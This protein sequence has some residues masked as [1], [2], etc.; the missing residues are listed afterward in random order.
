MKTQRFVDKGLD[1]LVPEGEETPYDEYDVPGPVPEENDDNAP[2]TKKRA[3]GGRIV[4]ANIAS[5]PS[6]AQKQNGNYAKDHISVDGF[7]ITIEN[8]KGSTR[9]GVGADGK[10]WECTMPYNY[11][12]FK[13]SEG[14]DGDHVD[15]CLGPHR[16]SPYVFVVDQVDAKTKKF[17]EH[18]VGLHWGT[19]QQ[20][21]NAYKRGFSDGKGK[22]RIGAVTAVSLP[23]F[24]VWLKH[25]DTTKPFSA[26]LL[27][28]G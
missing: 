17:D 20:F 7:N 10:P 5:E 9:S 23:V 8:A 14:A 2:A 18:K 3:A 1:W 25:A 21:L 16:K 11:G 13:R 19:Q 28:K 24:K 4:A 26:E 27:K 15:V 22:D 6:D 12:Y